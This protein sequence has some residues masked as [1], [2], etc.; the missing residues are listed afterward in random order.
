MRNLH[1][2]VSDVLAEMGTRNIQE[3]ITTNPDDPEAYI[4]E[5]RK[6][7]RYMKVEVFINA[8]GGITAA[9]IERIQFH[10]RFMDRFMDGVMSAYCDQDN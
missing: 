8:N 9:V 7:G 10:R 4:I 5:L 6:F 1:N 2:V 3:I